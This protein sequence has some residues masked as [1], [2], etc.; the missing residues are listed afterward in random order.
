MFLCGYGSSM[1]VEI[2]AQPNMFCLAVQTWELDKKTI[3]F[4]L[5]ALFAHTMAMINTESHS[6]KSVEQ[7]ELVH[8]NSCNSF[9]LLLIGGFVQVGWFY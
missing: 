7:L 2:L 9:F 1:Y 3:N 8:L 5:L 4:A 6:R